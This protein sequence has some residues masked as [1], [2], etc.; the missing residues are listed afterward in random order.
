MNT[1]GMD[2]SSRPSPSPAERLV[3]DT[4]GLSL[5]KSTGRAYCRLFYRIEHHG[6]EH[7]PRQGPCV[8]APNHQTFLDPV[9]VGA[10]VPR[11]VR[12]LAREDLFRIPLFGP[13]IRYLGAFPVDRSRPQKSAYLQ[14]QE[15]LEVNRQC[16][17]L[18]PEGQRAR[19][20]A[21]QEF[22][23]GAVR[24]ALSFRAALV[25]CSI[26]GGYHVWPPHRK[27]PRPGKIHVIFHPPLEVPE[28]FGRNPVEDKIRLREIGREL[29]ARVLQPSGRINF[30]TRLPGALPP[31]EK[32]QAG[33]I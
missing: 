26:L 3:T 13:F 23:L 17:I 11:R 14:C 9:F 24:L 1:K 21:V 4:I 6:M 18:F 22:K 29:Q 5:V 16:L 30:L 32:T 27:L 8:I 33:P 19:D 10:F 15:V 25:P 7:I 2:A 28:D 20:G 12:F 31:D